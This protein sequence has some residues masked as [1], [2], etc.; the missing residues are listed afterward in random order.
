MQSAPLVSI[1][2]SVH[3]AQDT[4]A[5]SIDSIRAQSYEN[6]ELVI[7]DD[8][9]DD[10]SPEILRTYTQTDP[11]IRVFTQKNT[12]LTIALNNGIAH[13]RGVYIARQDADDFSYPQRL[14]RQVSVMEADTS[15]VLCG[16]NCDSV[17]ESGLS[18]PWGWRDDQA[19]K[20]ILRF[21]TPFAHSTAMIRA[22]TLKSLGGY[23]P[24]FKT[25]QDM[26]LWIRLSKSGKVTM[27]RE[28]VIKRS[29]L[30]TTSVSARRKWRQVYDA[31]RARWIHNQ[32]HKFLALYHTARN[33][34]VGCLPHKILALKQNMKS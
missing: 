18:I 32:D 22:S 6:W 20:K 10:N 28:P 21:R 2:M 24:C 4:L 30:E 27:L 9:S 12:G 25:S 3:N 26:E 15:I 7:V 14:E 23:D 33:L 34:I 5:Q 16:G 19:L 8:G 29:V 17:Y 31:F 1:L 13:C 11:R